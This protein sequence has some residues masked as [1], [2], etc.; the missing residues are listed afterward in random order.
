MTSKA[1]C[2]IELCE[3]SVRKYIHDKTL[4]IVHVEGTLNLANISTKEMQDG[5][6]FC[7]L[8]DSFLLRLSDFLHKLV[9]GC[10][11]RSA[12][13]FLHCSSC[14][15]SGYSLFRRFLFYDGSCLFLFLLKLDN[16]SHLS[17]ASHRLLWSLHGFVPSSII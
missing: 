16:I 11:S 4:K 12:T 17:S 7:R 14:C 3:N 13:F 5:T 6:H 8:R 10:P 9:Y 2:H 1:A 15:G